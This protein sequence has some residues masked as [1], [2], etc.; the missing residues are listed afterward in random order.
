MKKKQTI[1]IVDDERD[2]LDLLVFNARQEGYETI[3]VTNGEEA[4]TTARKLKPDLII[5][6]LMLPGLDGLDVSRILNNDEAT[7]DIPIIMLTAKGTEEDVVKGFDL[8]ADDYVTKP[9]SPK[10]LFA[11][12]KN[13]LRRK[14]ETKET[15]D[16]TNDEIINFREIE[17]NTKKRTVKVNGKEVN[18]TFSEFE[19]LAF[20]IKHT[21]WAFSRSEIVNNIH[22]ENYFVTDRA[23]DVQ[24]VGLRKKLGTAAKYIETVRGI[25]YKF[26]DD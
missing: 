7:K 18:L 24:I 16:K 8:G 11:R 5:L 4:I 2:I 25:G 12:V 20:L 15:N 6:D 3:A 26:R 14:V 22:G 19:I 13:V 1:L 21:G 23:V 9:F 17:I 10:V